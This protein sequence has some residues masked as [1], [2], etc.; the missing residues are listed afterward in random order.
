MTQ[1]ILS[2]LGL[3]ETESGTYLGNGEWSKTTNAGTIDVVNPSTHAVIG[4]VHASSIA[5]Y[6]TIVTR[7]Q[8]A[9][10]HWRSVPRWKWA[11]S[12]PKA[13]AKCRR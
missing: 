6:E 11:R 8:E 9:F 2:A 10:K 13:T 3:T 5:D 4:R 1:S 12:S 7:A